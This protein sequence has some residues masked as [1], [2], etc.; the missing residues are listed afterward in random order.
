M[1][2]DKKVLLLFVDN[3][4]EQKCTKLFPVEMR[5]IIWELSTEKNY[6][7]DGKDWEKND[8]NF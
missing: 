7:S 3:V 6:Y 8:T 4:W 2:S 1:I 5:M